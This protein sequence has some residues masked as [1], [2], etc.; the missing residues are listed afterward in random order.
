MA[1]HEAGAYPQNDRWWRE[2]NRVGR[3]PKG[4][5]PNNYC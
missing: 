5:L 2:A 1:A 4:F 3:I